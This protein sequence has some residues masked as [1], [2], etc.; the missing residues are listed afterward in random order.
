MRTKWSLAAALLSMTALSM[1]SAALAQDGSNSIETVTVTATGT[2]IAGVAPVGSESITMDRQK[3]ESTGY[4]DINQVLLTLP[5][6]SNLGPFKEGG[7]AGYG[8]TGGAANS[9]Q[10]TAVNLRGLGANATLILVDGHRLTPT[11]AAGVFTDANQVPIA[12]LQ[13][14][15]IVADGNSAIYGSDAVG[16]VVNFVLRKDFD[17]V[18]AS[19][20]AKF[21]DGYNEY[22]GYITAGHTWDH[23]F[24][25]G[26]GNFVVSYDYTNRDAMPA[27]ARP[28][29][30]QNL[31]PYGGLDNRINNGVVN[32][33]VGPGQRSTTAV[34]G[35]NGDVAYCDRYGF[36]S[37]LSSTYVYFG[38]P[39]GNGVGLT[40]A[41]LSA[42]P[43]L[44][45]KIND[46]QYLG[47]MWRHQASAFFNQQI[48][49]WLSFYFEGF[50]T[51]KKITTVQSQR[52]A[53]ANF[54]VQV[55]PGSPYYIAPPASAPGYSYGGPMYIVYN[56]TDHV[57][58]FVTT[59][60]DENFTSIAGFKLNLPWEWHGDISYTYGRD[61]SCGECQIGTNVDIGAF[62]HAV[63]IGAINPL[64][65]EPLTDAQ[66]KMVLGD[67]VQHSRMGIKDFNAKFNG[68]LFD[69]PGGTV[70]AAFGFEY[71]YNSEFVLNGANRTDIAA[72]GILESS[73]L[74]PNGYEGIGCHAPYP[75]PPRT[76]ANEFAVDNIG[77]KNR[78]VTSAYAELYV[79]VVGDRNALPFVKSFEVDAAVRYDHYSDFGD[80]TNPKV[81]A[82]WGVNDDLKIR[83]S[84]G[85][86]FRAPGLTD[87]NPFVF[88]VKVGT[89]FPNY[90]T[91]PNIDHTVCIPGL[92]CLSNTLFFLGAPEH[93]KPETADT[94]SL[95]FDY[96]PSWL[97]GFKFSSTYYN[98][99]YTNQI[100][101]PPFAAM[102]SSDANKALY[103]K[104][105]TPIHNPAGCVNGDSST[106]DPALR[107]FVGAIGIYGN[108]NGIGNNYCNV[109]V[110]LDGRETNAGS[111]NEAGLDLN[112]S[113]GFESDHAGAWLFGIEANRILT[114]DRAE[115]A[116]QP[117]RSVLGTIN[118]LVR[119]RGR[120][121]ITW[122]MD[123][124]TTNLFVNYTGGYENNIPLAG[125]RNSRVPAWITFD[126]GVTYSFDNWDWSQLQGTRLSVNAIN[127][128]D[129][130]PP[131]V[132]TTGNTAYDANEANVYGRMIT[133]QLTKTF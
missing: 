81:S 78:K 37:C 43:N 96:T 25:M 113:Y 102:L 83:G 56:F 70:R 22:G 64:S 108:L 77:G 62:Q 84:W 7:T 24:G 129:R 100:S 10:G 103:S 4:T 76:M 114:D 71:L 126:A 91:D 2:N 106:Y 19:G 16:G 55:N 30:A 3:I 65:N 119:W 127:L 66:K 34:P 86:S 6:V 115:V 79:P 116:G 44:R 52:D 40:A 61:R 130:G 112:A 122:N 132:L 53:A 58:H 118:N 47:Q 120:G 107:P 46:R 133:V 94:W 82:T 95:G 9:T 17:G 39:A 36:G 68:P 73:P 128:F 111:V 74:P 15:E 131:I 13:R 51:K 50:Y 109:Q 88:S 97:Q 75:C 80:T 85:T 33:G 105:V 67:N 72:E 121:S 110:V 59:N 8:T 98:V 42:T 99:A 21:V 117:V 104:Y 31:T 69:M 57:S 48:T 89:S 92:F 125:H 93:L 38:L 101:S 49:P 5:Q 90:T 1:P 18:Q 32:G 14:I 20:R 26:A 11:G 41:S 60:P 23:L 45:D 28:I 35:Y 63:N 12:A 29:L 27:S 54:N 123:A 87:I 124:W